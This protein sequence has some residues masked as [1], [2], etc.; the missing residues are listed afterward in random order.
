MYPHLPLKLIKSDSQRHLCEENIS[1]K[2]LMMISWILMTTYLLRNLNKIS[3]GN[4]SKCTL[5]CQGKEESLTRT[6]KRTPGNIK[7][8]NIYANFIENYF[9]TNWKVKF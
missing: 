3:S 1:I 4:L 5:I 7:S 2:F 8:S 6:S 9:L